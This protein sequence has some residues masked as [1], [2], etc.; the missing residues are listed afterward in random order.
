MRSLI[1][2]LMVLLLNDTWAQAEVPKSPN[3][4]FIAID[5][6]RDWVG[7][8]GQNPQAK[9]PHIDRLAKMGLA[10]TRSY[11]AAPVCNPSRCALMSGLRPSSSGVYDNNNDWRELVAEDLTLTS[12]FRKAG[13]F[14][15][16][17]G[18][19]YHE[20]YT[21]PSEWDDYLPTPRSN[22]KPKGNDGVGGIRFA[23][24]DCTDD[25]L[26]D[27]HITNYAIEQLGKQHEK[28]FFLACGLHKPHMAWNVPRKYYDMHPLESIR[29]P[30]YMKN[31]LDDV[32]TSGIA[33]AKPDGDH[34]NIV[35]SGRWKEAIQGY[36]AAGSYTDMNV[37][38][39]L[40]ALNKSEYKDNT[41][42]V[43]WSDHGWHLG[44]KDYW[45]KFALW[46]NTTRAPLLWVVPGLT[47][48]GTVSDRTVDFMTIF[49]TLTDLCGIPTPKHVEGNS[50]RALLADPKGQ[51]NEP[52]ITTFRF[53]NHSVRTEGWRY[54]RYANGDEEL[55]DETADPN[56]WKNLAQHA[57]YTQKKSE[58]GKLLPKEDTPE[59]GRVTGKKKKRNN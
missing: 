3:V 42:I 36:L 35:E 59:G 58:L 56:E 45:R 23:P 38:R 31:D 21:R 9:T 44:E 57:E 6:L 46:E 40:D 18:K 2:V 1:L 41:I 27:W 12:T 19:I 13:Y 20:R 22:P 50:I 47:K 53:K 30:P 39:L 29:L 48:P 17:A 11:C 43:F 51:W 7:Y 25:E 15:C 14:V 32:P 55:Y 8:L 16:G 54:I 49:P 10:L 34:K 52:A 24:L 4:L 26:D 37:G 28:P 5:D 33:M